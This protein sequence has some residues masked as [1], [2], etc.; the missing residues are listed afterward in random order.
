MSR[1]P[2]QNHV[3]SLELLIKSKP[4]I[5]RQIA[6]QFWSTCLLKYCYAV[7]RDSLVKS[8][9]NI[10]QSSKKEQKTALSSR[11]FGQKWTK[12]RSCSFQLAKKWPNSIHERELN[13]KSSV[14]SPTMLSYTW[15][16]IHF[17]FSHFM[18]LVN[19][20]FDNQNFRQWTVRYKA[21][22]HIFL[23]LRED[24]PLFWLLPKKH[25]ENMV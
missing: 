12:F 24:P 10:L 9:Q 4:C 23:S 3:I 20:A 14:P 18:Y 6:N 16:Y 19:L 13:G 5:A 15:L 2:D 17:Y 7:S 21:I 11:S 1:Q 25:R 8:A 22:R